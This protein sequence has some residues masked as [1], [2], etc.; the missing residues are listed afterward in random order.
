MQHYFYENEQN[1]SRK[2]NGLTSEFRSIL[3]RQRVCYSVQ[4]SLRWQGRG[5]TDD[6]HRLRHLYLHVGVEKVRVV[7]RLALRTVGR[8]FRSLSSENPAAVDLPRWCVCCEAFS[9]V[10]QWQMPSCFRS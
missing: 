2:K 9:K 3:E 8:S 1:K 10:S 6:A 4:G 7:K 5:S